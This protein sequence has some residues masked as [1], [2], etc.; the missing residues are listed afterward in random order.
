MI[1]A[2]LRLPR[3][4]AGA[5]PGGDPV[6]TRPASCTLRMTHQAGVTRSCTANPQNAAAGVDMFAACAIDKAGTYTLTAA[7]GGLTNAVSNNVTITVG[8]SAMLAFTTSPSNSSAG[9]AFGTQPVVAVQD[10]GGNTRTSSTRSVTLTI[11]TPA[12]ATLSCTQNPK[13]ASA[14]VDA[15]AGCRIN[16]P[17]TYTLTAAS[18]GL[19]DAVSTTFTIS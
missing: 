4:G 13:N 10:A 11:T 1:G 3:L 14:G 16:L 6:T 9:I 7:S 12:G 15:F 2:V 18:A 5:P 17:G 19:T 8:S